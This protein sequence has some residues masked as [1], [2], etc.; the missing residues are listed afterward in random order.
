[1]DER[2]RATTGTTWR[3]TPSHYSYKRG[4]SGTS[5]N[6]NV[7]AVAVS[8]DVNDFAIFVLQSVLVALVLFVGLAAIGLIR[9]ACGSPHDRLGWAL[10]LSS[11]QVLS[12]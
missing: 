6:F 8:Y 11:C 12:K 9:P 5:V 1:M 10:R 7:S 4:Q 2:D 3:I